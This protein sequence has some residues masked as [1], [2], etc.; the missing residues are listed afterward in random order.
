MGALRRCI[1]GLGVLSAL[2]IICMGLVAAENNTTAISNIAPLNAV[3]DT[4]RSI[5][6]TA[7]NYDAQFVEIINNGTN[8]TNI[9]DWKLMNKEDMFYPFPKDF[10]LKPGAT[11]KVHS[12]AGT[13]TSTDLYRSGLRWNKRNDTAT[14]IDSS[15]EVVSTYRYPVGPY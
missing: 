6:I 3:I 10:T 11:V 14:L 15:G 2:F 8:E 4:D 1:C 7:V 13:D 9:G 5:S 12:L